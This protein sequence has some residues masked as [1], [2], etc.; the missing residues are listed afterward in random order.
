MTPSRVTNQSFPSSDRAACGL[1]EVRY[2]VLCTPSELSRIIPR[3]LFGTPPLSP[4]PAQASRSDCAM[5]ISPHSVCS[6]IDPLSSA[7]VESTV[8]HG[9]PLRLS[10]VPMRPALIRRKPPSLATHTAPSAATLI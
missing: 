9:K 10:S 2:E 5:R 4:A 6:Q 1:Y 3:T 7:I 8:S